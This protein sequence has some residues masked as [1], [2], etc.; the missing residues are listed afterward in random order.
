MIIPLTFFFF[1]KL[2]VI[3]YNLIVGPSW[4][5]LQR[6]ILCKACTEGK[7]YSAG[8]WFIFKQVWTSPRRFTRK[9]NCTSP[10]TVQP[11]AILWTRL[12]HLLPGVS[13]SA[14]RVSVKFPLLS[15]DPT[16]K[17]KGKKESLAGVRQELI[18]LSDLR[19]VFESQIAIGLLSRGIA[20]TK[21]L[22]N[23]EIILRDVFLCLACNPPYYASL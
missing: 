18:L 21:A 7:L 13:T 16:N 17:K 15:N 22:S 2:T 11:S 23:E 3:G 6:S 10:S 19:S 5:Y 12:R 1:L 20:F 4:I 14:T 9:K 8:S